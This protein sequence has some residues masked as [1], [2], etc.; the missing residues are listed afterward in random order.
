MYNYNHLYYFYVAAKFG[1]ISSA[2]QHL[3]IS[4]PSLSSQIRVLESSLEIKLF[5][6]VGRR[7]LLT[8]DG[9]AIYGFCR[10][11]FEIAEEMSEVIS[12]KTSSGS[13]RIHIGIS[14]EVDR[15]FVIEIVS[16]FLNKHSFQQ[17]PKVTVVSGDHDQLVERVRF[18][19]LDAI[20][21]Q[22][23]VNAIELTNLRRVEV[24]VVLT[25]SPDQKVFDHPRKLRSATIIKLLA[26]Q[27]DLQWI[28]PSPKFKLR[29]EI[30]RFFEANELSGRAVFESDVIAS[31]IRSVQDGIGFAFMPLLYIAREIRD[32]SLQ[33]IGPKNGFWN[34]R[35]RLICHRQSRDD[36]LIRT[37]DDVFYKV[38]RQSLK[39]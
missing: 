35:V 7:S 27:N 9:T 33:A 22:K 13:R 10:R 15:P 36:A 37:L 2:A 5:Q 18:R 25:C 19:E 8:P 21:T 30:D 6:K 1:G 31:M 24:P 28:V 23:S 4:Q 11:M 17:R 12:N 32:G 14:N 26:K 16:S 29:S 3:R 38:C 39:D 20:V 34:Y